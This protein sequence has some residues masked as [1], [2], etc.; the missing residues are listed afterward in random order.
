MTE[1]EYLKRLGKKISEKREAMG[2]SVI[3]LAKEIEL[4][5]VH[6][7]RIEGG[8]NPTSII[9]LRRIAKVLETN[10]GELVVV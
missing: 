7:Y 8:E 6:V 1:K 4:S 9:V 10:I 2:I 5:K 3:E